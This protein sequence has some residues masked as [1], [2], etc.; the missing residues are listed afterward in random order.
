M[1]ISTTRSTRSPNWRTCSAAWS[2]G[3]LGPNATACYQVADVESA[4]R[5]VRFEYNIV[6]ASGDAIPFWLADATAAERL[7]LRRQR[8]EVYNW[9][10]PI[11]GAYGRGD[12]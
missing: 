3:T 10:R 12:G 7:L 2:L 6:E 4:H 1:S 9:R 5:V 8:A 11:G